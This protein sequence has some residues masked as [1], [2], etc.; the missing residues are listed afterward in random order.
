MVF[1]SVSYF[2][3]CPLCG[4][5]I[6]EDVEV[7]KKPIPKWDKAA[8]KFFPLEIRPLLWRMFWTFHSGYIPLAP[9]RVVRVSF[10]AL[11]HENLA[12]FLEI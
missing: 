11:H 1:T 12:V 2:Y 6:L 4:T 9:A 5:G 3:F 8:V 10:L 7:R